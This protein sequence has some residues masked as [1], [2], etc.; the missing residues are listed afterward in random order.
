MN[1]VVSFLYRPAEPDEHTGTG[2]TPEELARLTEYL[3]NYPG[4]DMIAAR[5]T[6]A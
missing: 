5:K 4:I 6:D 2:M 1:T 3:H